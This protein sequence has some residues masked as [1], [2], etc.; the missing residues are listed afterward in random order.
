MQCR[1]HIVTAPAIERLK[2]VLACMLLASCAGGIRTEMKRPLSAE[3][4]PGGKAAAMAVVRGEGARHWGLGIG[5]SEQQAAAAAI[6][7]CAD[8]RCIV[9][10]TYTTGQCAAVVLGRT[11][12]FWG[13]EDGETTDEVLSLCEA[14]TDHCEIK[15]EEC[16]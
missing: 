12:V 7:Q 1:Q 10:Q 16:L 3:P 13:G 2:L 14:V 15:R 9:V 4:A 6:K 5:S 11:Q 8:W